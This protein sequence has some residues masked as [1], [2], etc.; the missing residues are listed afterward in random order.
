MVA[1]DF[2]VLVVFIPGLS[3]S[4]A[5]ALLLVHFVLLVILTGQR[6]SLGGD[7]YSTIDGLRDKALAALLYEAFVAGPGI[8]L[9]TCIFPGFFL[10]DTEL[11]MEIQD[12]SIFIDR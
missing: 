5:Q 11:R 3:I 2:D 12:H 7:Y 1:G 8:F 9:C 6:T 10:K 4:Q